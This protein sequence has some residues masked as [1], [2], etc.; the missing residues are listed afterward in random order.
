MKVLLPYGE[1]QAEVS[2]PDA[3][4]VAYPRDVTAVPDVA[5]E[6]RR[7]V[8][9]T[10][11]CPPL[12][13]LARGKRD[14]VVVVNDVTRPAPS[15]IMLEVI[16]E[17]LAA[18]AIPDERITV[19]VAT[20][21]HRAS[22]EA[23]I[24]QMLG[25]EVAA[26]FRVVN[27]D[28][29]DLDSLSYVGDTGSGV[30]VWVN[31]LVASADVKVLTGL[32]TPHHVAGYSG[33]RKSIQPGVAGLQTI[34]CHH[35]FPNRPYDP[36][37]GWMKGNVFHEIAVD[38]ARRVRVDF[39]VNVVKN[40]RGQVVR[41]VAGEMEAAH[42][43]GVAICETNW[44]LNFPQ[45][46]DV[47]IV[48]PGGYPRDI[49]LHQAQKAM[50]AAEQVVA[51]GGVIVLLAECRDGVGNFAG[52]LKSG[53]S[54]QDVI[55]R[56]LREGFTAEHSS[57][58][59]LCARAL[60]VHPVVVACRGIGSDELRAMFFTPAQSPQLAVDAALAMKGSGATVLVLPYAVDCV[61][62]VASQGSHQMSPSGAR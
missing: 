47:V 40:W 48:T 37:M 42:E 58:A 10:I 18:A 19:V 27:H 13:E 49:N 25:P 46:Y 38:V 34:A 60:A 28:C 41:A 2:L 59:F 55:D 32:I 52:W 54:P 62:K 35:S 51:L 22:T 26:R 45:R 61:P 17:E 56:F 11:G 31:R 4:T 30:P 15:G 44:V 20:G 23:E 24:A 9:D 6:I 7:S 29:N 8:A 12:R 16:A 43:A 1:T 33:G 53:G 3:A 21:N 36:A 57:K 14:A 5:A 50:S 39:I